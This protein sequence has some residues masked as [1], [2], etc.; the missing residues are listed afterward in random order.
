MGGA[1]T[2]EFMEA[3][4]KAAD[5]QIAQYGPAGRGAIQVPAGGSWTNIGPFRSNWIQNGLQVQESDT[6]RVRTF[7]VHPT[8]PDVLYVLTS[9]GG[10][11]KTTNFSQPRPSWR[12]M[13]DTILSTSGGSAALG[14]NPETIYLG[15]GD[16]FD[17]GVGGYARRSTD[18]GQTWSAAIKL[19]ASTIIPDVKVDTSGAT[20]VVLM[21]TNAGLVPID[22]RGRDL[23]RRTRADRPRLEP[24][25]HQCGLARRAHCRATSDRFCT[26]RTRERPGHRFQTPV[27]CTAAPAGQRWPWQRRETP[28]STRLRPPLVTRHRKICIAPSTAASTGRHSDLGQRRRS[29]PTPI[30]PTWTSWRARRS[31]TTWCWSIRT[32]GRETRSTSAAS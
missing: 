8:N 2:P 11:W 1:L 24:G 27:A 3:M 13:T 6:G 23:R 22:G 17:P 5:E 29:T 18:G 10:L 30:N 25:A 15:T 32:T 4:M 28:S 20:D 7:L 26:R 16:P 9:S 21:G 12:A 14:K 31:T 19:G